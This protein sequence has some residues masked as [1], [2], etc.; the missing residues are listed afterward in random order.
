MNLSFKFLTLM[1]WWPM[2][3]S[4]DLLRNVFVRNVETCKKMD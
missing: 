3:G 2:V 4:A 1:A